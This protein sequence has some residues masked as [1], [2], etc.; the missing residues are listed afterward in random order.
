MPGHRKTTAA[1]RLTANRS[2]SAPPAR[3][4]ITKRNR[5]S[6]RTARTRD[7][8]GLHDVTASQ[9]LHAAIPRKRLIT[10]RQWALRDVGRVS[11][12]LTVSRYPIVRTH[13]STTVKMQL[14]HG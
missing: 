1:T 12:A 6:R 3:V 5:N 11:T 14:K 10:E 9:P 4:S 8:R 7:R 2:L 13:N